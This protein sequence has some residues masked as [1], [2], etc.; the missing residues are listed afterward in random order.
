M[1]RRVVVTGAGCI[2]PLGTDV[3]TVWQRS[4]NGQSG[5]GPL[6]LFDASHF[7]VRIAAEVKDWDATRL[8][9][10]ADLWRNHA[11]QT[12]FAIAAAIQAAESSGI[13][14]DLSDPTRLGLY[15]GCGEVFQDFAEFSAAASQSIHG[16]EFRLA[17]FIQ[18]S[19]AAWEERGEMLYEPA[20]AAC[21]LSGKYNA[22]GPNF[23]CISACASGNQAIGQALEI[24]RRADAD[25][26]LCGAGHSMIHP[27]GVTGFH[28]LS[29]LSTRNDEPVRASRPFDRQRN[30]FVVGEGAAV[31]VLE[32]L[33]HARRRGAEI[34]G[35]IV[36]FGSTQDAFRVTDPH[37]DGRGAAASIQNALDDAQLNPADIDYINAHGTSTVV[38]DR[39]ETLAIKVALG[40]DA[41]RIPVSST[42]SM[43]GHLTT[44]GAALELL[45]CLM[46][47]RTGVVPPTINYDH[48]DPECDLDYV[49]NVAREIGCRHVL[50]NSFGFGGQNSVLIASRY[51]G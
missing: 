34:W 12:Q 51:D 5:V 35:E 15:L 38:N 44:A 24:I 28:R 21:Y 29:T 16:D 46:A 39:T 37:P 40:H 48:P 7:P 6:T 33:E 23:N 17:E 22:Q 43:V 47:L 36:G 50:N 20:A 32:E 1:R 11:R 49:P 8:G 18:H 31:F 14:R 41:Y 4:C 30:G 25:L 9:D 13:D 3:Q 10:A 19:T 45:I 42:K 27:F 2:T 26:M